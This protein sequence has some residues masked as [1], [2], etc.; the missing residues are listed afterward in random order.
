M[1]GTLQERFLAKVVRPDDPYECWGWNAAT[2]DGYAYLHNP[3]GS[4]R[5]HRTSWELAHGPIP[6]DYVIDHLCRNRTCTNPLHLEPVPA[7]EN[8]WR[9]AQDHGWPA[10]GK[11]PAEADAYASCML[12]RQLLSYPA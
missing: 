3:N 9:G 1:R 11:R 7:G 2:S 12:A 4:D 8:I 10:W 6:Q 5:A